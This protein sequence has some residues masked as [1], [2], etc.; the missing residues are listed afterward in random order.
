MK[1][2]FLHIYGLLSYLIFD[3]VLIP[4]LLLPLTLTLILLVFMPIL[5]LIVG[6]PLI[7]DSLKYLILVCSRSSNLLACTSN[8]L[9]NSL[10]VALIWLYSRMRFW[11]S[12]APETY[13]SFMCSSWVLIASTIFAI[14]FSRSSLLMRQVRMWFFVLLLYVWSHLH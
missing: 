6:I 8:F 4:L 11:L 3:D 9:V 1:K 14:F 13:T 5:D 7:N 12:E 10:N 2:C